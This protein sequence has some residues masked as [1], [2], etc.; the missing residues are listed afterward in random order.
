MIPLFFQVV[1]LDSASKAGMRLVIPSLATPIG[2]LIA[3][4]VMSRWGMLSHLVR[5]GCFFM[6]LG[7]GLVASLKFHDESWKYLIYLFPANLGQGIVYPSILFTNIAAFAQ[8][9]K[10]E[11]EREIKLE[12]QTKGKGCGD[13]YGYGCGYPL[14]RTR[15]S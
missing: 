8:A 14:M 13:G 3:G 9:G 1:L 2:G 5:L 6:M 11:I 10:L 15:M 7:N 12:K 4:F